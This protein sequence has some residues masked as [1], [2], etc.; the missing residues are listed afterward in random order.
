MLFDY[1]EL[2]RSRQREAELRQ[3]AKERQLMTELGLTL[4]ETLPATNVTD[5][6]PEEDDVEIDDEK[7]AQAA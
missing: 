3:C 5:T 4:A 1:G 6:D 7:L 2:L